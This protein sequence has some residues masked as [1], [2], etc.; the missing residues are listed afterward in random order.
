VIRAVE[1]PKGEHTIELRCE[2]DT[3]KTFNIINL[4]GSILIVAFV[5]GAIALPFIKKRK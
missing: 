1:V 2:P 3:L 5:L 4:I